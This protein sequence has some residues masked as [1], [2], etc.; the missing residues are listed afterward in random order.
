MMKICMHKTNDQDITTIKGS[1][2]KIEE[3]TITK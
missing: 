1:K 2:F 3:I